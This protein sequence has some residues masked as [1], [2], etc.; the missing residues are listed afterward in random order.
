MPF[1]ALDKITKERIDIT[2]I[3]NPR[4]ELKSGEVICQLCEAPMIVKAGQIIRPHFAH[5]SDCQTDYNYHPQSPEHLLGKEMVANAL[6][7]HFSDYANA[8]ID[9]EVRVPEVKRVADVMATFQ[10]GWRQA[11]EVQLAS[12]TIG[13][14]DQRTGDYYR[15]GVDVV[16]YL[17]NNAN[18]QAN[19]T[20]C[21]EKFGYCFTLE[22]SNVIDTSR[23]ISGGK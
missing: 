2:K 1:V 8:D 6:K 4:A 9:F 10:N 3:E 13:D 20:W 11:H 7:S 19:K 22:I 17:G 16:W 14:L 5:F 18:T 23:V 12:I 21:L 15:A